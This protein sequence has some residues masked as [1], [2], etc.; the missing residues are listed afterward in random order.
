METRHTEGA[1]TSLPWMPLLLK[2]K[3]VKR[4]LVGL[5]NQKQIAFKR[6]KEGSLVEKLPMWEGTEVEAV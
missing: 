1:S 6:E 5:P 2:A 4:G 3:D